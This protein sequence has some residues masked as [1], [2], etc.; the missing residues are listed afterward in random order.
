MKLFKCLIATIFFTSITPFALALNHK[1]GQMPA[2]HN[3]SKPIMI[4]PETK[5]FEIRLAANLSTGYSWFLTKYNPRYVK[6]IS[7]MYIKPQDN[8]P[9][10]PGQEVWLFK[11]PVSNSIVNLPR[12]ERFDNATH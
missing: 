6:P 10:Q 8:K 5:Q 2:I 12:C 11:S 9:G 1:V 4:K 7:H 3:P